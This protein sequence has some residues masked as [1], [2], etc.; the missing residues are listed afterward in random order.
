M[1][2]IFVQH[3]FRFLTLI[4]RALSVEHSSSAHK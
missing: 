3:N 2:I 4:R 1:L